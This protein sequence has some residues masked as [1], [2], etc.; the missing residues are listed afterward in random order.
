VSLARN[1][2]NKVYHLL[3]TFTNRNMNWGGR[4]K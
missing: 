3:P 4:E 2:G 1:L